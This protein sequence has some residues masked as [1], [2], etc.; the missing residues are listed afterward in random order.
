M[1]VSNLV[2]HGGGWGFKNKML[3]GICGAETE[4]VAGGCRKLFND[5]FL[6]LS[7]IV[8]TVRLMKSKVIEQEGHAARKE[9]NR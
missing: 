9:V 8:T 3:K 1:W 4:E 2:P 7:F 5:A 6:I